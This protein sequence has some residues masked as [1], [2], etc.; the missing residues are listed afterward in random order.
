[1]VQDVRAVDVVALARWILFLFAEQT[2]E[3]ELAHVGLTT[4]VPKLP[5]SNLW[6]AGPS[7]SESGAPVLAMDVQ[8]PYTTPFQLCEARLVSNAGL[9]VMGATFFG[10]PVI[11]A[12]HNDHI[13]WS[14]TS[15][16][17]DVF[18]LYEERL[19]PVNPRRYFYGDE[20]RRVVSRRVK[21][22]MHSEEG[23]REVETRIAPIPITVP[24]YKDDWQLG[25]LGAYECGKSR[26]CNRSVIGDESRGVTERF[27][28]RHFR[29]WSC[30]FSM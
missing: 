21:I 30:R 15:N 5:G 25:I 14:M 26:G 7:R 28:S 17:I 12:G 9:N 23:M 22:G 8:L 16:D 27:F 1:M 29:L 2:G 3:S 24:V 11:F 6:V 4:A 13:A 19:D 20:Q 10:L 18:D